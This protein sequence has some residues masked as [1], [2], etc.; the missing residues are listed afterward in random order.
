M[1]K[2][3]KSY[4]NWLECNEKDASDVNSDHMHKDELLLKS[5]NQNL[6]VIVL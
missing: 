2:K 1:V 5:N 6:K 4:F 3:I